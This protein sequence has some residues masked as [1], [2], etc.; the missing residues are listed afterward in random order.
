MK[1]HKDPFIQCLN[2]IYLFLLI[3]NSLIHF[4]CLFPL[5]F[6][7]FDFKFFLLHLPSKLSRLNSIYASFLWRGKLFYSFFLK[8]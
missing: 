3:P 1:V 7:S 5:N 4:L 2:A 6:Y 8:A